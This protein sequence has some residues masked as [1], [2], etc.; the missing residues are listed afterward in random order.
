MSVTEGEASK[1]W[2]EIEHQLDVSGIGVC[3]LL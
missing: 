1:R 3:R 2:Q